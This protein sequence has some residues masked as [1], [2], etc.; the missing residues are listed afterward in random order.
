[1]DCRDF[2]HCYRRLEGAVYGEAADVCFVQDVLLSASGCGQD[3]GNA[4]PCR[5]TDVDLTYRR[6]AQVGIVLNQV[7]A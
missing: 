1:M 6:E 2:R 3:A 4:I 5:R 7:S